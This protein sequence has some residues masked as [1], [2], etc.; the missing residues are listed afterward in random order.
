MTVIPKPYEERAQAKR[1]IAQA[2]QEIEAALRKTWPSFYEEPPSDEVGSA[3]CHKLS[4]PQIDT[5]VRALVLAC[6]LYGGSMG[7]MDIYRLMRAYLWDQDARQ[8]INQI[9]EASQAPKRKA[10]GPH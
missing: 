9:I 4:R 7:D 5:G 10:P 3:N 2:K 6:N 8:R 1:N